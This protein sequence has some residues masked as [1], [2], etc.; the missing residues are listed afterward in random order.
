M[1]K[2]KLT[3]ITEEGC[4]WLTEFVSKET[5]TKEV[6][7]DYEARN[8]ELKDRLVDGWER[9]GECVTLT[10]IVDSGDHAFDNQFNS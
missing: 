5:F 6:F 3:H 4:E 2:I 10:P 8:K 1:N 7:Q 9:N